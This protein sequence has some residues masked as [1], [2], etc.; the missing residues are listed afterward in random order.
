VASKSLV[1]RAVLERAARPLLARFL[2]QHAGAFFE[3]HGVSLDALA[4][5]MTR[6][7]SL[8]HRVVDLIHDRAL[9]PALPPAFRAQLA[10]LNTLATD[11]G[12]DAILR[13]DKDGRILRATYGDEDLALV[14][15]LDYPELAIEARRDAD[16]EEVQSFTEYELAD[17]AALRWGDEEEAA[18]KET[19]GAVLEASGR[20]RLCELFR[21]REGD[22]VSLEIVNARRPKTF[23]KVDPTSLA[24][25]HS[26]D[27]HTDRAFVELNLAAKTVA[28]HGTQGTKELV[29]ASIGRVLGADP[30]LLRPA[31]VY[32]LSPFANLPAA[33]STAGASPRLLRVELHGIH[34]LTERGTVLSFVRSRK[35]LLAD[36]GVDECVELALRLGRPVGVRLYLF[37]EGRAQPLRLELQ[38]KGGKNLMDFDRSDREVVEIVRGYLRARGVLRE[39]EEAGARPPAPGAPETTPVQTTLTY[40]TRA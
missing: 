23:D 25:D 29:R 17:A 35:D 39:G 18:L 14:V 11:A 4:K 27:I 37:L 15:L 22:V 21:K 8:V 38:T 9:I 5:S 31:R 19:M 1:R 30:A 2:R 40:P 10:L 33:L 36:D 6:E 34:V 32:D 7:R 13:A 24:L 26:T 12:S 20:T 16:A 3:A 28:I